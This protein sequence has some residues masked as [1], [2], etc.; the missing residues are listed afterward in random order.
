M[1]SATSNLGYV[2]PGLA[3]F[4]ATPTTITNMT[5]GCPVSVAASTTPGEC[6][7]SPIAGTKQVPLGLIFTPP[8][9]SGDEMVVAISGIAKGKIAAGASAVSMGDMLAGNGTT[10]PGLV[11]VS[12]TLATPGYI[13][14]IAMQDGVA[15]DMIAVLVAPQV[16]N[17]GA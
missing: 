4:I 16:F 8:T 2:K 11:I 1:A 5:L 6:K 17:A 15:G 14:G 9:A 7:E 13:I 12:S 3:T 10:N